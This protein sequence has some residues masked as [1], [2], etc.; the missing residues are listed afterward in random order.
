METSISFFA[1]IAPHA[2]RAAASPPRGR[3]GAMQHWWRNQEQPSNLSVFVLGNGLESDP[4]VRRS[5][6]P[7]G[8]PTKGKRRVFLSR[9]I[10]LCGNRAQGLAEFYDKPPRIFKATNVDH[11]RRR[12]RNVD[13]R[14]N[15][16][17]HVD[18]GSSCQGF[19][20]SCKVSG[21]AEGGAALRKLLAFSTSL[22]L[23]VC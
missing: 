1:H 13:R 20:A 12:S 18:A 9:M 7:L 15:D 21:H 8:S 23:P 2:H 3:D 19:A 11:R 10:G 22:F 5:Q 6:R 17:R 14:R 4:P 16:S